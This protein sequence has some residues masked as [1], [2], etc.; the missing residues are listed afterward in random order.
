MA[1]LSA[2]AFPGAAKPDF[3]PGGNLIAD[4]NAL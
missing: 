2:G 1:G 4:C 3:L